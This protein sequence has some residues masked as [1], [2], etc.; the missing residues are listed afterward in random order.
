MASIEYTRPAA[1]GLSVGGRFIH[2]LSNVRTQVSNWR[3][4]RATQMELSRLSD[5]ELADIGLVRGD[6][7]DIVRDIIR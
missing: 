2:A 3:A 7:D 1:T 6:I 5:A 4:A